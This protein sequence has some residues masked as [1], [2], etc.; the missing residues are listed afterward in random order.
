MYNCI[1][2]SCVSFYVY[3]IS[4]IL[5]DQNPDYAVKHPWFKVEELSQQE[6]EF[7]Q[8]SSE[9]TSLN[10]N[11][12]TVRML[13][14]HC[15]DAMDFLLDRCFVKPIAL[16]VQGQC[17]LDWMLFEPGTKE[18]RWKSPYVNISPSCLNNSKFL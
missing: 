14:T 18:R 10:I 17:Y 2:L 8:M 12:K 7:S 9:F 13:L 5:A 15:P 16:Q 11:G 4:I 3:Y 1:I 6:M